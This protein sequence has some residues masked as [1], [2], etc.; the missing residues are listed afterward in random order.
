MDPRL[1]LC[2]VQNNPKFRRNFAEILPKFRRLAE[3]STFAKLEIGAPARCNANISRQ[4]CS[5]IASSAI[6]TSVRGLPC[7]SLWCPREALD[8]PIHE[9]LQCIR[10][11]LLSRTF[12]CF[13]RY[14][15]RSSMLSS[16]TFR[17]SKK[18]W[19][20]R[21]GGMCSLTHFSSQS[22]SIPITMARG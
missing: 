11:N 14:W 16:P 5:K 6:A 17:D 7:T 19:S 21:P 22:R 2:P 9:G 10:V 4:P 8:S 13:C 20:R 15:S 18:N 3:I 12:A 1:I